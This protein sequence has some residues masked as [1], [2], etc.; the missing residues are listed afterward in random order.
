MRTKEKKANQPQCQPRVSIQFNFDVLPCPFLTENLLLDWIVEEKGMWVCESSFGPLLLALL[1]NNARL[2]CLY[3]F[4]G[5]SS[6]SFQFLFLF[7]S[8]FARYIFIASNVRSAAAA[9]GVNLMSADKKQARPSSFFFSAQCHPPPSSSPRS[10]SFVTRVKLMAR[11][12]VKV[13]G[14]N[15]PPSWWRAR[16]NAPRLFS[17]GTAG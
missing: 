4:F 16:H 1:V 12:L 3:F 6:L 13:D 10:C 9:T 15:Q 11:R 7:L 17:A 8:P 14:S 2:R 5:V